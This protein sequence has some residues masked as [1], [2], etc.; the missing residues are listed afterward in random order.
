M[1]THRVTCYSVTTFKCFEK[2]ASAV[3]IQQVVNFHQRRA[4]ALFSDL[5]NTMEYHVISAVINQLGPRRINK[6]CNVCYWRV[7]LV[8]GI[9]GYRSPTASHTVIF[10]K[11]DSE[12]VCLKLSEYVRKWKH[13]TTQ[14]FAGRFSFFFFFLPTIDN[15]TECVNDVT[16]L[17]SLNNTCCVTVPN[18]GFR[19]SRLKTDQY[20]AV[21][22]EVLT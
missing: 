10:S 21:P 4:H 18:N 17:A 12:S 11:Y 14:F 1:I 5:R 9:D 2:L 7:T 16:S 3:V 19:E 6:R 13:F 22:C 15:G 8:Q 20:Y